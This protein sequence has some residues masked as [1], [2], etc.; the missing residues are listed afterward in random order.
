[1]VHD[2]TDVILRDGRPRTV[3]VEARG[4]EN[5]HTFKEYTDP[6]HFAYGG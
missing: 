1:M 6:Y 2:C 5:V 3:L 4:L